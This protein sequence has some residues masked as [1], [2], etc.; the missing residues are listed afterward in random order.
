ME[1]V[2]VGFVFDYCEGIIE[3][4]EGGVIFDF[5]I[6]LESYFLVILWYDIDGFEMFFEG[7]KFDE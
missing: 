5:E 1:V 7:F 2:E 4:G 6:F 3:G